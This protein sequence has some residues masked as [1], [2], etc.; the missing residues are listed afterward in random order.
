MA[1][2]QHL[3]KAPIREALIDIRVQLPSEMDIT[4]LQS[5][6]DG[7]K[8]QYPNKAEKRLWENKFEIKEGKPQPLVTSETLSGYSFSTSTQDGAQVVQ[9]RVDGFTFSRLR[10]YTNWEAFSSEAKR[11]WEIYAE[12]LKDTPPNITRVATRYVNF[13]DLPLPISD[14]EQFITGLPK[15]PSQRP[16]LSQSFLNRIQVFDPSQGITA[17]VTKAL[18]QPSSPSVA[19]VLLDIDVFKAAIFEQNYVEAWNTIEAVK[20][21]GNEIFF[22]AITDKTVETYK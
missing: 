18:I 14:P 8:E 11:L 17:I 3:S 9:F 21:L 2:Y 4:Q 5:L 13:L 7:I 20:K 22:E 15:A 1:Q 10:P 12:F 19:T 6:H 16:L